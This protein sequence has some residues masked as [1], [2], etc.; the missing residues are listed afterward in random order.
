MTNSTDLNMCIPVVGAIIERVHN[1]ETEV[2]V[3]TRWK[4]ERDPEYSGTLEMPV[5]WIDK[6]E[7]VYDGLMRKEKFIEESI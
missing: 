7:N 1:G 4:P 3:Q 5:G 6:Y 2:L